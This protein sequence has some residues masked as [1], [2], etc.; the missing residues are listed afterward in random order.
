MILCK[1]LFFLSFFFV[2]KLSAF[3]I[4]EV[5]IG[6]SEDSL[7]II[8][9]P[10]LL[11]K[12]ETGRLSNLEILS[13]NYFVCS[14]GSSIQ[15]W[16]LKNLKLIRILEKHSNNVILII[17]ID[18]NKF[19]SMDDKNVIFEWNNFTTSETG[20]ILI[21]PITDPIIKLKLFQNKTQLIGYTNTNKIIRANINPLVRTQLM[22]IS[23]KVFTFEVF[24]DDIVSFSLTGGIIFFVDLV[25][26]QE[27]VILASNDV[28]ILKYFSNG[29]LMTATV[30]GVIEIFDLMTKELLNTVDDKFNKS[31]KFFDQIDSE[32]MIL[33]TSDCFR[34]LNFTS[35]LILDFS[36]LF[37]NFQNISIL[38]YLK[39]YEKSNV[40][41]ST[42]R[43]NQMSNKSQKILNKKL[44]NSSIILVAFIS[45]FF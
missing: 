12:F 42:S 29:I 38:K 15:L 14:S 25:R 40:V 3:N 37:C 18:E 10:N 33:G 21:S 22:P 39:Y 7:K 28:T 30:D 32:L 45:F 43:Q 2:Y 5:L 26:G 11:Y 31:V 9:P 1:F 41:T 36:D 17:K 24:N 34:F 20:T 16:S 44:I 4:P 19:I 35:P 27:D 6:I 23:D 8:K 13:E